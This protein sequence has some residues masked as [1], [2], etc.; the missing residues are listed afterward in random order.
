M[1]AVDPPSESWTL[2]E[3]F[4]TC[5]PGGIDVA[6]LWHG[7]PPVPA[8]TE[9][10]DEG[11][12]PGVADITPEST[13][14]IGQ[15]IVGRLGRFAAFWWFI[16]AS[17]M[18]VKWITV[19]YDFPFIS[20]PARGQWRNHP[21]SKQFAFFIDEALPELEQAGV[22]SRWTDAEPPWLVCPL[23]V[24][25]KQGSNKFRLILDLRTMSLEWKLSCVGERCSSR[26]LSSSIWT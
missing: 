14:G 5:P 12:E 9:D 16:G 26:M 13:H 1:D 4:A 18:I 25:P 19:G 3:R 22:V 23:N 7:A 6:S 17:A 20:T 11:L 21:G 10:G 15:R 8:T 24:V 2:P